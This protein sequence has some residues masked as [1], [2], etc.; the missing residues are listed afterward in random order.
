ME[1][2]Q[3]PHGPLSLRYTETIRHHCCAI[4][5]HGGPERSEQ[6]RL[7]RRVHRWQCAHSGMLLFLLNYTHSLQDLWLLAKA[8]AP[9]TGRHLQAS[10]KAKPPPQLKMWMPIGKSA[11]WCLSPP[12]ASLLCVPGHSYKGQGPPCL[13]PARTWQERKAN[14][15]NRNTNTNTYAPKSESRLS[16]LDPLSNSQIRPSPGSENSIKWK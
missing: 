1:G 9:P 11:A 13:S 4:H 6:H 14:R 3:S 10:L 8:P 7:H 2:N 5:L 12:A 16:A 15:K